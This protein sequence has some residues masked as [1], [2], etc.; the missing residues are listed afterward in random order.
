MQGNLGNADLSR[1][2][3]KVKRQILGTARQ[4]L[5]QWGSLG[6]VLEFERGGQEL[7]GHFGR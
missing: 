2:L 4:S 5:A 6:L 7:G 1:L 3:R